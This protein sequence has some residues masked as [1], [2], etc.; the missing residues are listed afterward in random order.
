[1]RILI[2][3]ATGML[4]HRIAGEL[5]KNTNYRIILG[6]RPNTDTRFLRKFL[7]VFAPDVLDNYEW[8]EIDVLWDTQ[9]VFD[10]IYSIGADII[11]NCIGI[12]KHHLDE[13]NSNDRRKAL[14]VNAL[15]P[16][17][18]A[19]WCE[20]NDAHLIT[21]SSDCVF[22]G[23]KSAPYSVVSVPDS[24]SL[25]GRTKALGEV[26]NSINVVTFRTSFIGF[27]LKGRTSLLEWFIHE[28]RN[29]GKV[30]GYYHARWSGLT[31][32]GIA[33][34]IKNWLSGYLD[35]E[36]FLQYPDNS[37]HHLTAQHIEKY[38]LLKEI[39]SILDLGCEIKKSIRYEKDKICNRALIAYN[40]GSGISIKRDIEKEIGEDYPV[41]QKYKKEIEKCVV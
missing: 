40:N 41:Y 21:F 27:E 20:D 9:R 23:E 22:S 18:L 24:P 17:Q 16:N 37:L 38:S 12:L 25:Y 14:E 29:K 6:V 31:T 34:Y 3:G 8:C 28:A 15:F 4:G 33:K 5:L 10:G 11:I 30:E 19:V 32:A 2:L 26:S 1:M 7:E 13:S 39:N 36:N 35:R